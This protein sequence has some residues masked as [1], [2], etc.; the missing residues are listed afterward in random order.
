[1]YSITD[2]GTFGGTISNAHAINNRGQVAGAADLSCN[3]VYH[4]F[5]WAGDALHDL[6]I[7]GLSGSNATANGINDLGQVVGTGNYPFLWSKEA[8]F[9][10]L[11]YNGDAY[12]VNNRGE[13][14][15]DLISPPHAVLWRDGVALDLGTLNGV[16]SAA[17]GINNLGQVVGQSW[18]RAFLWTEGAGMH[19][20]GTL[21]GLS[22]GTSGATAI[23]DS[24]QIVGA[25]YSIAFHTTHPAYF[26][27]QGVID[28][29]SLGGDGGAEAVN[30]LGQVVGDSG[31]RAFVTDLY[32]GPMLDLN[33]LIPP[34]SGWV[35]LFTATGINDAGQIIGTGVLPGYE[36]DHAYLLTP[37]DGLLPSLVMVA[38]QSGQR[39]AIAD[40]THDPEPWLLQL[41]RAAQDLET[42][43]TAPHAEAICLSRATAPMG[44]LAAAKPAAEAWPDALPDVL[45]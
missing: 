27:R 18:G 29:G 6:S 12:K 3:C 17:Y 15:G 40:G 2:L 45:A 26:T 37:D 9:T 7:L 14:V 4:P 11:G 23:N 1:M 28:L 16:G 41:G 38:R 32:G 8:G 10:N 35:R 39:E 21:D 20:L 13:V 22:G 25:S 36:N 33:T 43:G 5:L 34:D 24:G 44:T 42:P 31:G 19:D 30:N